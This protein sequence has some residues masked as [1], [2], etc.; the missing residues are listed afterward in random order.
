M[1]DFYQNGVVTTLHQLNQRPL[2]QLEADLMEFRKTRP[3]A[4]VLPS[5]YSELEGH[6][7][8]SIVDELSHVPY[9]E[10]IVVGID[11]AT[12]DQFRHSLEFFNRLPQRP[13]VLWNDG[14]RLR[15]IDK[16]LESHGLAPQ[17]MGKGRNVWY[18]FG[19]I[20]A[21][22]KAQAVALHDCD[23]TTYKRDMLARLI[24]P[25]ANPAFSYK[26]CKGYYAR[27]AKGS[28]NGRVCRLLVTPLIRALK[29]VCGSND[30]LDYLDSFRYALAGEFSLQRDVIEDIRIPSDWGLEMG[31]IS[32]MHRNYSTRMICQVDI[33][34]TYDHKHQELSPDDRNKG[35]S[36]M[37]SDIS[38]SLFRKMATQGTVFS[39]ETIRTI[40]ATYYRIALDLVDSYHSDATING[41]AY[42]RHREG[43]AVELFAE[44]IL[45]AGTQFLEHSMAT[46]FM[47]SWNRVVSAVPDIY[48]QLLEAVE[49]D[50]QE[51]GSQQVTN[52][53][54]HP[55]AQRLRQR[56]GLHMDEIYGGGT[57]PELTDTLLSITGL[58]SQPPHQI[59][60]ARKWNQKD[61]IMVTYGDTFV[62]PGVPPLQTLHRFLNQELKG[63]VSGVHILPF[64]PF[65]S[66]DGFSVVD[67]EA[68]N[69]DLGSWDDIKSLTK[70]YKVMADLVINH[71]SS[72]SRWFQN[73]LKGESPGKAYFIE[74]SPDTDLSQV[75]RPR[76][77]PLLTKVRTVEGEKHVWCTF[78]ADQVDLDYSNPEVLF[79]M[80]RIL[81]DYIEK[82]I[83]FFRL[84]A[85]AFVWKEAGTS[86]V[87]LPQ[88]H[89]IIK[90]LRLVI[91][92]LEPTAVVITETNVP[93]RE[94]LSYFG[95]DNEAHLIYNFSLPPLLINALLT[96]SS[97]Y[98]TSW[99]MSMPPA[100]Q[101]RGYLNFIASHDGIGVRPAEGLLS[102]KEQ[103]DLLATLQ[104]FGG[105]VSMRK[106]PDGEETPYEVNI[107]LFDAFKGTVAGGPDDL[108][109]ERFL[110]AH[111]ILLAL[112]G[113]PAIYVHSLLAT[114]NDH[115]LVE[116]TGRP[117]SINRHRWEIEDLY[118]VLGNPMKHNRRV[119]DELKRVIRIRREQD[120]FHPNATQ[121]TLHFGDSIFGFWRE[122]RKRDQ[123]IFALHNISAEHQTLSLVELNL[124]GTE[125]WRDLLTGTVFTD[126]EQVIDLAPYQCLWI[127][128]R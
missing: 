28:M 26:F 63:V 98:L 83:R 104:S 72:Q 44:N 90:L 120:A 20:L 15:R 5:L 128:N 35:L 81:R 122:S 99:M 57:T 77:S 11:R 45:G 1:G 42:D 55:E 116:E 27:V 75:V 109:A 94:N 97:K 54:L 127:S 41:L 23:I 62:N 14:P 61:V 82:G 84:D 21:S 110:C 102:G 87:H 18:M 101:G 51:F 38:K 46:P 100:R 43:Q 9:L 17:E 53:S 66:D 64:S 58:D 88:T 22:G 124:I 29:K 74:E 71:C 115:E 113:I 86:C 108:Q 96:G 48:D 70:D 114:E 34:S 107:S 126:L 3:M 30:Y 16:L 121:Y 111:T 12:E 92:N 105:H 79:E 31:V 89:E 95:N 93:N 60:N 7:L 85:V 56:V 123:N 33:A 2:G 24:Y 106:M 117:R 65:S 78:S 80:V 39:S 40:K 73:Y 47:P 112:E 13:N 91:E 125:S 10:Q 119:F 76:S 6:A 68:V 37:S 59:A 49:A 52:P 19:Y 118:E 50:A 67:Y 8:S 103:Q 32:E 36:K 69:P 4:L 25:V